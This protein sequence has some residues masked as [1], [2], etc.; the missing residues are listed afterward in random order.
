M[1]LLTTT[2]HYA[3]AAYN[4]TTNQRDDF[5]STTV[6]QSGV[7]RRQQQQQQ[8]FWKT[9][10]ENHRKDSPIITGSNHLHYASIIHSSSLEKSRTVQQT[11]GHFQ[12]HP[13]NHADNQNK[14]MTTPSTTTGTTTR[15]YIPQNY[16]GDPTGT[17][18]S[19]MAFQILIND[20]LSSSSN[21]SRRFNMSSS[22][23]NLAAIIDLDGGIYQISKPIYI[24]P[25]YG[26]LLIKNGVLRASSKFEDNRY[27][28]EIGNVDECHPNPQNGRG[29]CHQFIN[30]ENVMIDCRLSS[31]SHHHHPQK[32][33]VII[34]V[35]LRW[36]RL[37]VVPS[38]QYLLL[39]SILWVFRLM[40]DMKL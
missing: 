40:K 3:D 4:T 22:I 1:L 2:I 33:V 37:W 14:M 23:V 31:S 30:I 11:Y 6:K 17:E 9:I 24:P 5:N 13:Q 27:M 38:I 18:D 8:N 25:M 15:T 26:N 34:L 7:R 16:G 19:T 36:T 12:R 29:V 35:V 20:M 10:F 32:V 28:I 21:H 39:V